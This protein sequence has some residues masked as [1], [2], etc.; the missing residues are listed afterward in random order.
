MTA[1]DAPPPPGAR[2]RRWSSASSPIRSFGGRRR[3]RSTVMPSP[4]GWRRRHI[5]RNAVRCNLGRARLAIDL[6]ALVEIG[7]DGGHQRL[8]L[9]VEEM[10][11]AG[12]D[13]LVDN[14]ALLGLELVDQAADVLVRHHRV[15]VAMNDQAGGR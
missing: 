15:L 6:Q 3:N 12:H 14:D 8:D 7:A 2:T 10:I 4:I 9:G 5:W 1:R 13:L 11:G